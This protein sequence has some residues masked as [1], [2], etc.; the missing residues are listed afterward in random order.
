M[1]EVI[2]FL[3]EKVVVSN[4]IKNYIENCDVRNFYSGEI[5]KNYKNLFLTKKEF[6]QGQKIF[7]LYWSNFEY[8]DESKHF[9]IA[10]KKCG[11]KFP[12]TKH[13]NSIN[14]KSHIDQELDP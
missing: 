5:L 13:S 3:K 10:V 4:N 9:D 7:K 8:W 2:N 14:K 12:K 1:V 11:L 6:L